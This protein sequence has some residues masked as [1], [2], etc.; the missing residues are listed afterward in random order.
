ML[1]LLGLQGWQLYPL[2]PLGWQPQTSQSKEALLDRAL[3]LWLFLQGNSSFISSSPCPFQSKS[4]VFLLVWNSKIILFSCA[5]HK[6]PNHET[7]EPSTYLLWI[8]DNPLSLSGLCWDGWL[9]SWVTH[10]I[11]SANDCSATLLALLLEYTIQISL[12]FFKSSSAISF[13][14]YQFTPR[15]VY[16]PLTFYCKQQRGTTLPL[17]HLTW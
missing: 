15:F 6:T 13:F 9:D 16:F 4:A 12:T 5:I 8:M 7:R 11:S 2:G 1:C 10:L 17:P 14:F 3:H